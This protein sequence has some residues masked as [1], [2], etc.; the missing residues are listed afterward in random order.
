MKS[1][2]P[3]FCIFCEDGLPPAVFEAPKIELPVYG[4]RHIYDRVL[5]T[6][7]SEDQLPELFAKAIEAGMVDRDDY[8][9][10][11]AYLRKDHGVTI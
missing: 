11:K 8:E 3:N 10:I 2:N 9:N 7:S 1:Y 5:V 6:C 4:Q